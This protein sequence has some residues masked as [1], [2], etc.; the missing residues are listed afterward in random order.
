MYGKLL[1]LPTPR[2]HKQFWQLKR[3]QINVKD[4]ADRYTGDVSCK[5]NGNQITTQVAKNA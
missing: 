5:L 3:V 2:G 1:P 4:E